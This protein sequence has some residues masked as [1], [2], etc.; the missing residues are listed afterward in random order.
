MIKVI[1][2]LSAMVLPLLLT[3]CASGPPF[4]EVVDGFGQPQSTQG[5]IYFYRPSAFG[6]AIAPA[7]KLNGEVIGKST[8]K[9]FF[10]V[11]R[12]AGDYKITTTTEVKRALSLRLKR[13]QTRYVKLK[14][15]MGL[16]VGRVYPELVNSAT[17]KEEIQQ[18]KYT[19]AVASAE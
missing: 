5:R 18:T 11:D 15:H 17:G 8:A 12:K 16:M 9:G 19:G 10:Y 4:N 14:V 6:A 1:K 7:V 13:G 2:L 3:N